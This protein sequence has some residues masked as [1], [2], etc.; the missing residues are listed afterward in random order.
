MGATIASIERA[1]MIAANIINAERAKIVKEA[2]KQERDRMSPYVEQLE[3]IAEAA[4]IYQQ[5]ST[6][7]GSQEAKEAQKVLRETLLVPIEAISQK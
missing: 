7:N 1:K 5:Y 2:L 4:Y 6:S 3:R